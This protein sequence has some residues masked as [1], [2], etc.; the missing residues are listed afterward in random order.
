MVQGNSLLPYVLV[1]QN[2]NETSASLASLNSSTK[3]QRRRNA[4]KHVFR[5]HLAL[6]MESLFT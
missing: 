5:R 4:R 6:R 1:H 3:D 2:I